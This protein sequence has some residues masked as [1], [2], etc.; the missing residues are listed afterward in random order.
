VLTLSLL[1]HAKSSWDHPQLKDFDRPLSSRGEAAAPRIGA[2]MAEHGI[3]PQ[4][5]LVSTAVR[6]RQTLDLVLPWLP[7]RP[8][9]VFEDTLYLATPTVMLARLRRVEAGYGHVM[10]VAHDPGLH[11]LAMSLAGT[12]EPAL[13]GALAAKFPTAALA[14]IDFDA[15]AWPKVRPGGGRLRL[16]VT[17][18]RLA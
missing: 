10:I 13:L 12:G 1:R 11:G 7:K 6:T 5:A 18:K 14:V 8:V 9:T 15:G 2:F 17:P 4:L 3:M 16:F